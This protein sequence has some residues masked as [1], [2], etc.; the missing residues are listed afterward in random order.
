MQKIE[1]LIRKYNSGECSAEERKLLEQWYQSFD[2]NNKSDSIP[3][4]NIK[5]LKEEV[6]LAM[7][8]S[9]APAKREI[10]P[11]RISKLSKSIKC[12]GMLQPL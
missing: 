1:D 8:N 11:H 12:G 7:Q 3:D 4:K 9:K 10:I 5:K 2:W 6:W